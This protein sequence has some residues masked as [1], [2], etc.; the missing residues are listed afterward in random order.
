MMRGVKIMCFFFFTLKTPK[1][2]DLSLRSFFFL[3]QVD[4][5]F[6]G[7]FLCVLWSWTGLTRSLGYFLGVLDKKIGLWVKKKRTSIFF[8]FDFFK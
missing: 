4:F 7:D 2:S 3:F 8:N 6:K 1:K 5:G